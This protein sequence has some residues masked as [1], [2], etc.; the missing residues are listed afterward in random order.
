MKKSILI[1]TNVLLISA[2]IFAQVKVL[3]SGDFVIGQNWI[4]HDFKTEINGELKIGL[5]IKTSHTW[6]F[7]WATISSAF[8]PNTKHWIVAQNGYM[9]VHNFHVRTSGD[10]FAVAWFTNSDE[11]FKQNIRS[12][13]SIRE[14]LNL[15]GTYFYD[16]KEGFNGT[17]SYDS[18]RNTNIPGFLAQEVRQVFPELVTID[19][20]DGRLF[21]NYQGFIPMLLLYSKELNT[22]VKDI[23]ERIAEL[24]SRIRELEE[25][26]SN[27][28]TSSNSTQQGEDSDNKTSTPSG[29]N[30]RADDLKIIP[31]PNKGS[32]DVVS[33][34]FKTSNSFDIML[35]DLTGK[36]IS[37]VQKNRT[38]DGNFHVSSSVIAAGVYY[39]HLLENGNIV[40]SEK[41]AINH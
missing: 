25:E 19:S 10:A 23:R 33:G 26:I 3:P 27:C 34:V 13:S 31:N 17:F 37:N 16:Y 6:G 5:G 1:L 4:S 22:E 35:T 7:G 40:R 41:V 12:M 32:F 21:L 15:V 36:A 20:S 30:G 11:R 28:C 24:N 29:F 39:V 8:N 18:S 9:G 2:N 38:V 14:R